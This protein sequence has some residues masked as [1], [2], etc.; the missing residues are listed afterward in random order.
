MWKEHFKN[1]LGNFPIVPDKPIT[2]VMNNQQNIKLGHFNQEL[3]IVL[4]KFK[5]RK[6]TCLDEILPE[7]WK[8]R[9]FDDLLL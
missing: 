4:R 8:T 6:V 3:N 5:N 7:A 2:K 9:K 1:L